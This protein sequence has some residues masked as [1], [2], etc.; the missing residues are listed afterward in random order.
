M[1]PQKCKDG[2]WYLVIQRNGIKGHFH[3]VTSK[4]CIEQANN[5]NGSAVTAVTCQM[6][7]DNWMANEVSTKANA[8]QE[9]YKYMLKY[10]TPFLGSIRV[11]KTLPVHCQS[12]INKMHK[13]GLSESTM[14]HARKVMHTFFEFERKMKKTIRENPCQDITIPRSVPSRERRSA[15][16]DELIKIWSALENTHYYY[17][18]QFLLLT[19]LRPSEVCGIRNTSIKGNILEI[20]QTRSKYDISSGK[21]ENANRRLLLSP[22]MIDVINNQIKYNSKYH[23]TPNYLFPNADGHPTNAGVLS[24][25]WKRA[26]KEVS[27]LT[28]YELR[29]TWISL[30]IDKMPLKDLQAFVGHSTSMDT[31]KTYAHIFKIPKQTNEIIDENINSYLPKPETYAKSYAKPLE[32]GKNKSPMIRQMPTT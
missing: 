27:D 32:K 31:S 13:K 11:S 1:K 9:Q 25:A 12:V 2:R 21:T 24:C 6:A 19:G 15:T 3:D 23:I 17:C 18:F 7:M 26:V 20:N 14:K 16:P 22:L 10:I 4:G 8:T 28:L 5:W 30:M 29:H